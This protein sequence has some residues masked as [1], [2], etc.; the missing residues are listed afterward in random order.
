MFRTRTQHPH[1]SRTVTTRL[2]DV[3]TP[4]TRRVRGTGVDN[5][6]L[7]VDVA[8]EA[9]ALVNRV[10]EHTGLSKGQV[11]ELLLMRIPLD[12]RGL[13]LWPD[14]DNLATQEALPIAKAD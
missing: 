6:V 4:K 1:C 14:I 3:S 5:V 9:K 2:A 8:P 10:H 13:P 11:T 7:R 12:E